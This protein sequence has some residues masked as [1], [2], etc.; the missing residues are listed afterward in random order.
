MDSAE[1]TEWLAFDAIE[2]L[3]DRRVEAYLAQLAQI[4]V[5][6]NRRADT[7]PYALADFLLFR[8]PPPP[9]SPQEL[10]DKVRSV[11]AA[12]RKP[13]QKRK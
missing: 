10:E 6:V 1:F 11:F 12:F 4:L 13:T 8:E 3:P 2:P 7:P 5:N 9:A